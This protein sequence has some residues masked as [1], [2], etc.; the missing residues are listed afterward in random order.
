MDS[1]IIAVQSSGTKLNAYFQTELRYKALSV[2]D[3]CHL[4]QKLKLKAWS[5][6]LGKSPPLLIVREPKKKIESA[7][8]STYASK[9]ASNLIFKMDE[10]QIEALEIGQRHRASGTKIYRVLASLSWNK[11]TIFRYQALI[12]ASKTQQ[13]KHN[14]NGKILKEKLQPATP[15]GI[16]KTALLSKNKHFLLQN[17]TVEEVLSSEDEGWNLTPEGERGN[18]SDIKPLNYTPVNKNKKNHKEEKENNLLHTQKIPHKE[19]QLPIKKKFKKNP[20]ENGNTPLLKS[21]PPKLKKK[22]ERGKHDPEQTDS[23]DSVNSDSK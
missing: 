11:P 16:S 15:K 22:A 7:V 5:P 4:K 23:M 2:T 8:V 21:Y 6:K 19:V 12:R 17:I 18:L 9:V 10:E 20:T 1:L 14:S 3:H 13:L